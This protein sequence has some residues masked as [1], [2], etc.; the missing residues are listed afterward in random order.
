M[1]TVVIFS[2]SYFENSVSNKA[3]LEVLAKQEN[4]EIRKLESLYP[5]GN[6]DVEAEQKALTEADVIVFQHPFFWYSVPPMLKKWI[7][8]VM[9][10]GF[11]YGSEGDKLKGKKFIHSFTTGG[12]KEGYTTEG[13]VGASVESL[14]LPIKQMARLVQLEYLPPVITHGL[15]AMT[16]PNSA[17][18]ALGHSDKLISRIAEAK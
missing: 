7:D 9:A 8:E 12:P 4:L 6:I 13:Y 5:D 16:N 3:I 10:Y 14:I 1:K 2:H 18:E 11:A 15:N 17:Q